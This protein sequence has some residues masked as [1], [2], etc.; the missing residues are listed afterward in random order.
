MQ[1]DSAAWQKSPPDPVQ[2]ALLE[3]HTYLIEAMLARM[4][5]QTPLS[6]P[7]TRARDAIRNALRNR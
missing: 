4:P 6:P 5:V 2:L 1:Q 3:N 7:A